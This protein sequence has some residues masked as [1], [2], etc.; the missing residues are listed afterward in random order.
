MHLHTP[1]IHIH[2]HTHNTHSH[3]PI[4]PGTYIKVSGIGGKGTHQL[5]LGY[6]VSCPLS[7]LL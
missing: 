1:T 2:I 6:V 5:A 7:G 3:T 4:D